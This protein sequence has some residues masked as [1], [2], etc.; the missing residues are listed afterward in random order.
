MCLWHISRMPNVRQAAREQT[1]ARRQTNSNVSEYL[2]LY[3]QTS[4]VALMANLHE[5]NSESR[6]ILQSIIGG[7]E[8]GRMYLRV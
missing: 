7:V 6:G 3:L 2:G 5:V 1:K 4:A 8:Y